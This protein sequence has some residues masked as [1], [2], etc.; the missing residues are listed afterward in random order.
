MLLKLVTPN[1]ICTQTHHRGGIQAFMRTGQ[2]VRKWEA[3][4]DGS[5][6]ADAGS[7]CSSPFVA[8]RPQTTPL[9]L[10]ADARRWPRRRAAVLPACPPAAPFAVFCPS[11]PSLPCA[12]L[13]P[14]SS[15]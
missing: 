6:S 4:L 9:P 2:R 15:P 8:V 7:G 3:V 12:W 1:A 10:R 5:T 13:V 14:P 11:S